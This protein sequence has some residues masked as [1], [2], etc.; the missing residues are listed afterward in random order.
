MVKRLII[1]VF[2]IVSLTS[3]SQ[4]QI[5][6]GYSVKDVKNVLDNEG[7]VI[8]TG[9]TKDSTFYI[10]GRDNLLFRVYY[11]DSYNECIVYILF[12]DDTKENLIKFLLDQGYYKISD[13][14]YNDTYK[15]TL[16]YKQ[17]LELYYFTWTMK[18]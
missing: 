18:P 12:I 14:F 11:F 4:A 17:D 15:V 7:Y 6:L 13:T 8:S 5:M 1:G 9:W 3:S 2:L 16:N 10:T